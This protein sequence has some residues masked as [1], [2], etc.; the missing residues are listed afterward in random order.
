MAA[1]QQS[2]VPTYKETS[3]IQIKQTDWNMFDSRDTPGAALARLL[4][5]VPGAVKK[6]GEIQNKPQTQNEQEQLGTPTS[7][8]EDAGTPIWPQVPSGTP[9]QLQ[10]LPTATTPKP[11]RR[12]SSSSR[13][14]SSTS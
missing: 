11:S 5:A 7:L 12:S 6:N 13:R 3:N 2:A 14:T 8:T 9:T 10:A 4:G 1:P